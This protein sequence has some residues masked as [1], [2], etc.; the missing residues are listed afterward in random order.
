MKKKRRRRRKRRKRRGGR[1]RKRLDLEKK[2]TQKR[3]SIRGKSA[4]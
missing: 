3:K 4:S 1:R 2:I